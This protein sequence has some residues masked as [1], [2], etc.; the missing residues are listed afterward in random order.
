[1]KPKAEIRRLA[2]AVRRA[3]AELDAARR[4]SE[5]N[6]AAKMLMRAKAELKAAQQATRA[7]S[8]GPRRRAEHAP[9]ARC[10]W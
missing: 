8:A 2:E 1:M 9:L 3:E 10:P 4:L 5:V 6:S 7:K